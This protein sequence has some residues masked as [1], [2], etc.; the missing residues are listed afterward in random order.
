MLEVL[1]VVLRS[2]SHNLWTKLSKLKVMV[3]NHK[4]TIIKTDAFEDVLQMFI[5]SWV[6]YYID[7]SRLPCRPRHRKSLRS[8]RVS[9]R[10]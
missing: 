1:E 5:E 2:K 7:V 3:R 9:L 4:Q 8:T 10:G 6:D